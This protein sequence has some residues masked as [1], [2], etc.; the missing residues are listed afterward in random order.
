MGLP[1]TK[2]AVQ[3][4]NSPVRTALVLPPLCPLQGSQHRYLLWPLAL[5]DSLEATKDVHVKR[6]R[7]AV[8]NR[9][10]GQTCLMYGVVFKARCNVMIL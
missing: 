10:V 5:W 6:T 3:T 9:N 7:Q 8:R 2:V 1:I 4:K